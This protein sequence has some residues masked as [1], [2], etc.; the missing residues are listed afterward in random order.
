MI[1]KLNPL[2]CRIVK[3][4]AESRNKA[5]INQGVKDKKF[6][7]SYDSLELNLLGVG[8]EMAFGK[9]FKAY[10][11]FTSQPRSGGSDFIINGRTIDVKTVN[12]ETPLLMTPLWKKKNP[13][14]LYVLMNGKIPYIIFVGWTR[15]KDFIRPENIKNLGHGDCFCLEPR[16]LYA[17]EDLKRERWMRGAVQDLT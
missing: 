1:V 3:L 13:S 17:P 11:D 7:N 16:E 4:I 12:H 2:E 6:V 15:K 10:P 9:L 14:D 8:G 5:D